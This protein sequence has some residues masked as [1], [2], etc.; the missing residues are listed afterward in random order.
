[1]IPRRVMLLSM[2]LLVLVVSASSAWAQSTSGIEGTVTD[3]T[4]AVVSGATVTIKNEETGASQTFQNWGLRIV[5]LYHT[6]FFRLHRQCFG[7]GIQDHGPGTCAL[8][9]SRNQ[10]AQHPHGGWRD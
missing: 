8:G 4:G 9:G 5:P 10:D 7:S 6:G 2:L 3:P 1:M